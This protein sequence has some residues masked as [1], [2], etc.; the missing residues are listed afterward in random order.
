MIYVLLGEGFEEVEAITPVD[1]LRRCGA[2]VKTAGIG[3][4]EIKG[5]HEITVRADCTVEEID[6]AALEM[7]VIPGGLGG[8]ASINGSKAALN[9]IEHAWAD[10]KYVAAICAGPTV[11]AGLHLSDGR[12]VTGY[13]G[14]EA[15]MGAAN[16]LADEVVVDGRL[17]TSRGPGTAMPFALKLAET[18]CGKAAAEQTAAGMLVK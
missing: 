4:L 17:I 5:A 12:R 16:C 7:L 13:P 10:G 9:A 3:G 11:L 18:V 15:Q 2:S 8:V 6:R 14:T 1:V